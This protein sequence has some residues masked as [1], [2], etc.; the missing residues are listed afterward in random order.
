MIRV[1]FLLIVVVLA[2]TVFVPQAAVF[3]LM[4]VFLLGV[5]GVVWTYS[6]P[7]GGRRRRGGRR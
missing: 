3:L 2:L 7:F 5:V 1:S 6:G 4:A